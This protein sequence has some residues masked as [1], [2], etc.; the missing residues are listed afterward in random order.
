MQNISHEND[1]IFQENESTGD[2]RLHTNGLAQR[3]VLPQRQKSTI[4]P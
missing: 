4:H 1:L 3:L 2:M